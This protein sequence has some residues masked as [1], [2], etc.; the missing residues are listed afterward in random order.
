[1]ALWVE[2]WRSRHKPVVIPTSPRTGH[3]LRFD[4]SS[5]TPKASALIAMQRYELTACVEVATGRARTDP[6]YADFWAAV[7]N[8]ARKLGGV[9]H[10][11]Q[12]SIVPS[13]ADVSANYGEDLERWQQV[14]A[15][16]SAEDPQV[17]STCFTRDL[18]L[19]PSGSAGLLRYDALTAFLTAL[20]GASDS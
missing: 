15:E 18:G 3:D 9:P 5:F 1:M 8:A 14:L 11:G 12:E 10:W 20:E 13:A 19:E 16:L 7:H 6:V 4:L 17:F 2:V